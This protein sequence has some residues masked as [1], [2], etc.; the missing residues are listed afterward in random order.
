MEI[1]YKHCDIRI[2]YIRYKLV[3]QKFYILDKSQPGIWQ[4]PMWWCESPLISAVKD[5]GKPN[6]WEKSVLRIALIWIRRGFESVYFILTLWPIAKFIG[7]ISEQLLGLK[8]QS[9][10]TSSR[11]FNESSRLQIVWSST[12]SALGIRGH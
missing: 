1:C 12:I 4:L 5:C 6:L 9:K 3:S 8:M 2:L 11:N 7:F 10:L